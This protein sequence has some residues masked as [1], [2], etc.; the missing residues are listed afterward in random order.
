MKPQKLSAM[1]DLLLAGQIAFDSKNFAEAEA[2]FRKAVAINRQSPY[3][4]LG[5]AQSLSAKEK[6][7]EAIVYYRRAAIFGS[8]LPEV[9]LECGT[10]FLRLGRFAEAIEQFDKTIS[11]I[12]KSHNDD[13][14]RDIKRVALSNKAVALKAT[15]DNQSSIETYRE[16]ILRFGGDHPTHF[17][18][19]NTLT[20]E[21]DFEE[22]ISNYKTALS[23]SPN[24]HAIMQNLAIAYLHAGSHKKAEEIFNLILKENPNAQTARFGLSTI[25][26]GFR[27]FLPGWEFY[28]AR[29]Q[30][31]LFLRNKN[32]TRKYVEYFSNI[33]SASE[34]KDK[35]VLILGEQ[36]PGDTIMFFSILPDLQP[37][38]KNITILA[39]RRLL[40]LLKN[41][42]DKVNF[43]DIASP[44]DASRYD[45]V[46]PAGDLPSL[47]RKTDQDFKGDRYLLRPKRIPVGLSSKDKTKKSL[48]VGISWR[49]GLIETRTYHRSM[50]VSK[51]MNIFENIDCELISLQHGNVQAEVKDYNLNHKNKINTIDPENIM[52]SMILQH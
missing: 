42:F 26:L 16:I 18:L 45:I 8:N 48:K 32:D 41:S 39:N 51:F 52:I 46:L 13:R 4:L 1:N 5:L 24:N 3:A 14:V 11:L 30:D 40:K 49:G 33:N 27:Q 36:G 19:A 47:F 15:G 31:P 22:A 7:D 23:F 38:T 12:K 25:Y 2:H 17:N 37:I 35:S 28:K 50:A 34:L 43:F 44:H 9:Q 6:A 21:G 29:W 10:S 20:S